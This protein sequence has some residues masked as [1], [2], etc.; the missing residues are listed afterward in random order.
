MI[1]PDSII[2]TPAEMCRIRAGKAGNAVSS[3]KCFELEGEIDRSARI[4]QECRLH[5]YLL[6]LISNNCIP[7]QKMG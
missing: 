5:L 6:C 1:P 3:V 4:L 7:A 2:M